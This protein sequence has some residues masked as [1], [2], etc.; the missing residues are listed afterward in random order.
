MNGFYRTCLEEQET[1]INIINIESVVK[2]YTSTKVVYERLL[3]KLGKPDRVFTTQGQISGA[4]WT[5][6]FRDKRKITAVLS[7]PL[8]IGNRK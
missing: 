4:E 2:I 3:L 1:L 7:R 5:I 8:L 6:P